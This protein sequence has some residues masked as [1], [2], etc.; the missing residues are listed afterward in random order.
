MCLFAADLRRN[1]RLYLRFQL[2]IFNFA[3]HGY[4]FQMM[5]RHVFYILAGLLF[6]SCRQLPHYNKE[7]ESSLV[8]LD[9]VLEISDE[10][11]ARKESGMDSLRLLCSNAPDARTLYRAYDALFHEYHKW[12]VDSAYSYALKK[13]EVAEAVGDPEMIGDSELDLASQHFL[14]NMYLDAIAAMNEIDTASV[15]SLGRLPEYRYLWYEIYHGLAQT[16]K[17]EVLNQK[18]RQRE[19]E[20]LD[21]CA[22]SIKSDCMEF[23]VTKGKVLIPQGRYDEVISL[24]EQKL[25]DPLVPIANKARLHYWVG[26]A[27]NAKGDEEKAMFH[28]ATSARYDFMIPLKTYGS[29]F[30]L[31]RL[32]FNRGDIKRAYR[33]IMRSYTNAMDMEDNMHINRIARLLPGII[34]QHEQYVSRNR[35]AM[36]LMIM[37][38]I[39]LLI[40]LS[41]AMTLLQRNLKRLDKAHVENVNY[42]RHL[43]ESNHIKDVYLGEFLSMFSEHI[44]GLERYRSTLR[45]VSKQMDFEA[46]QQELRS[47]DFIDSEWMYLHEKFDQTFLGLFPNFVEEVKALLKTGKS[48]G[49]DVPKGKLSNEFR[50][51]ALMRLGVSEPAR[52]AR[53]LRLSPTT[54]YNY[55]VKFRNA[56]LCSRDDFETMLMGIGE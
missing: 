24:I 14:S 4:E 33:Y 12:D 15:A 20:Y 56:A 46:I 37:S 31:A 9:Q 21:L 49:E 47:D 11:V 40:A 5:N 52:I 19:Q 43:Q 51:L 27:Y 7:V 13:F 35:R 34:A 8:L 29:A 32:C 22:E 54:V 17:S 39:V 36:G 53:F 10:L 25:A 41:F 45:V 1:S 16:V 48:I 2:I 3:E 26:R 30:S 6:L 44:D 23:Y 28:Y 55:R 18:Y 50:V 38:L 42:S